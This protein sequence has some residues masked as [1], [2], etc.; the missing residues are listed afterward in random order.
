[1]ST[2]TPK[3]T[4]LFNTTLGNMLVQVESVQGYDVEDVVAD[5]SFSQAQILRF[6]RLATRA[7]VNALKGARTINAAYLEE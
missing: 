4:F 2:S 6:E 7:D 3:N 1:M 5:K